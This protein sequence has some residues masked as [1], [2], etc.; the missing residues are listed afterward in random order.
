MCGPNEL[1]VIFLLAHNH[2]VLLRPPHRPSRCR[3]ACFPVSFTQ[4]L[5]LRLTAPLPLCH[6]GSYAS[7]SQLWPHSLFLHYF[8]SFSN[9][10]SSFPSFPSSHCRFELLIICLHTLFSLLCAALLQSVSL[11]PLL[12]VS[13][14]LSSSAASVFLCVNS[15]DAF[16]EGFH[17]DGPFEQVVIHVCWL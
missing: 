6:T 5:S 3:C 1:T 4:L 13:F 2:A 11:F 7:L 9:P 15:W 10:P 17:S 12:S 16:V 14:P 8:F